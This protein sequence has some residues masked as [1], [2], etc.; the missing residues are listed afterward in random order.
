MVIR[1]GLGTD[2]VE[3]ARF[4]GWEH[5]PYA[6]LAKIFSA[7]EIAYARASPTKTAERFAVRFAAREACCK[8]LH[9]L[10]PEIK[11]P[12]LRV[13]RNVHVTHAANG[14]PQLMINWPALHIPADITQAI[15]YTRISVQLSLTHTRT[16]ASATTVLL[17]TT[18]FH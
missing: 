17:L 5:K 13:L 18:A 1:C 15:D 10:L 7:Q 9:D 2:L 3:I 11:I 12:L 14:A 6:Q 8:A 16:L 4:A